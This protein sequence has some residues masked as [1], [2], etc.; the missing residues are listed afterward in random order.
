MNPSKYIVDESIIRDYTNQKDELMKER[1]K[2]A[3]SNILFTIVITFMY[4]S[5]IST[6]LQ[7]SGKYYK[8]GDIWWFGYT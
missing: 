7:L 5:D 6:D 1:K 8:D 4:Y 2:K 3:V